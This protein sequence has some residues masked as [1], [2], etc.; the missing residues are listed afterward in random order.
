MCHAPDYAVTEVF[1]KGLHAA[2]REGVPR[3]SELQ[4]LSRTRATS[5][6]ECQDCALRQSCAGGCMGRAWGSFGAFL[7]AED[8]CGQRRLV[9]SGQKKS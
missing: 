1:A 5:L 4:L 3:W 9:L 7:V 8:R 2:L 6:S